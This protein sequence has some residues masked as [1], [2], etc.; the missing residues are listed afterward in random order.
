[1]NDETIVEDSGINILQQIQINN[2]KFMLFFDTGCSDLVSRY[3]AVQKIGDQSRQEVPGPLNLGGV[4]ECKLESPHGI[5]QVKLPMRIGINAVLSVVCLDKITSTFPNYPLKGDVE[6]D[7]HNAF[8]LSGKDIKDLPALPN[9]V[10]G[11]VDFMIGAKYLCYHPEKIS[12]STDLHL[13]TLMEAMESWVVLI[14]SSQRSR[15]R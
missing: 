12:P 4:V 5:Y 3:S 9:Y 7:I 8:Q 15:S 10:S 13:K 1:M 6:K 2:N 11:D 14:L